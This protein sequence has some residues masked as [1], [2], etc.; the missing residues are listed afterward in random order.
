MV[1]L[2]IFGIFTLYVI[3]GAVLLYKLAE[4]ENINAFGALVFM[5]LWIVLVWPMLRERRRKSN[6]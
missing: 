1:L 5:I 2:A 4:E 3:V 6:K